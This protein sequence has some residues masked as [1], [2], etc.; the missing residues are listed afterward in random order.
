MNNKLF[1]TSVY[2]GLIL[3]VGSLFNSCVKEEERSTNLPFTEYMY[4]GGYY[5]YRTQFAGVDSFYCNTSTLLDFN[6]SWAQNSPNVFDF[7]GNNVVDV[8]DQLN[9][10]TGWGKTYTPTWDLEEITIT[11]QQSSG[12]GA[13]VPG[14]QIAFIKITPFDEEGED[15]FLPDKVKS[16]LIEGVYQGQNP[17]KIWYYRY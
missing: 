10:L 12:W 15:T 9:L 17:V 14:W 16:F 2:A 11:S 6:A 7:N 5:V 13:E 3:I 8:S 4:D 1:L